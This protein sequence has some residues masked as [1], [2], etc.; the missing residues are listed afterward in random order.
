M[1]RP[2]NIMLQGVRLLHLTSVIIQTEHSQDEDAKSEA[3][4]TS[5]IRNGGKVHDQDSSPKPS[6]E[7]VHYEE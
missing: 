5:A 6:L 1:R 2:T 7:A 3:N 4:C